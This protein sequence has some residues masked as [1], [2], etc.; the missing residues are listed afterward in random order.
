[1]GAVNLFLICQMTQIKVNNVYSFVI[2]SAFTEPGQGQC[3]YVLVIQ[4]I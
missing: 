2:G 1:M 4:L 3:V